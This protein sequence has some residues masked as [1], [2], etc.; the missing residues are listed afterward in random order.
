MVDLLHFVGQIEGLKSPIVLLLFRFRDRFAKRPARV[1][2]E[3]LAVDAER[4][5]PT[6]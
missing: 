6:F 2:G 1:A 4:P 3:R 5:A